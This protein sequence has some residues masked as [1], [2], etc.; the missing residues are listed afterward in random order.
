MTFL[1][2]LLSISIS[3][4]LWEQWYQDILSTKVL[5][6]TTQ[7]RSLLFITPLLCAAILVGILGTVADTNVR[8]DIF[9]Q[10][11]YL[12]LGALWLGLAIAVLPFWGL[13]ARDDVIERQNLAAA[14]SISGALLGVTLCFGG[15]NIG[16]GPGWQ[17]VVYSALLSTGGL[18]LLWLGLEAL[19]GVSAAV[20]IDRDRASGLR[21]AG[22]LVAISLVLGWAVAGDWRSFSNTTT[23]FIQRSGLALALTG[24]AIFVEMRCQPTA[25]CPNLPLRTHGLVPCTAYIGSALLGIWLFWWLGVWQ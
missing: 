18:F 17:A 22:F 15:G 14:Y 6:V 24:V 4:P 23:D 9:Y 16:N 10:V 12:A 3:S 8:A 11:F 5:V 7:G 2:F 21:L 13:S 20:T 1:L 25:Q 19:T